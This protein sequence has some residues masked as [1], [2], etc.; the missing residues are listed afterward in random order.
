MTE[1]LSWMKQ[2]YARDQR[3]VDVLKELA[4]LSYLTCAY[5]DALDYV[6]LAKELQPAQ[7]W[8]ILHHQA[9]CYERLG[10]FS[11]VSF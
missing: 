3:N 5:R 9:L 8:F 4:S 10:E 1:A 11:L 2:C 6:E 7:D